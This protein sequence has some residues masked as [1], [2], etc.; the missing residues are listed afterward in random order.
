MTVFSFAQPR[1]RHLAATGALALGL[2]IGLAMALP[3]HAAIDYADFSSTAGLQLNGLA[4]QSGS[5]IALVPSLA[6]SAGSVF[7]TDALALSAVT[8]FSTSFSFEVTSSP[9]S[10]LGVTDGFAFVLNGDSGTGASALGA[11]GQGLGYVGLGSSVAVVFRGRA[12]AL[13]GVVTGGE[14]LANLPVPFEPVAGFTT[15]SE[16]SFY[17]SVQYA[18]IDYT[19]GSLA[20]YLSSDPSKPATASMTASI[21]LFGTLGSSAHVGFTAGNGGAYGTQELLSWSLS[22]APVPE[23]GSALLLG[24]GLAGLLAWRRRG[25]RG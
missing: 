1:V 19:P 2:S 20:L 24:A 5:R 25:T 14:D 22:T 7:A 6:D 3:A 8:G 9:S 15:M 12:P 11:G 17:D 23:P 4:A 16:G 21:D 10:E 18:W 13:L